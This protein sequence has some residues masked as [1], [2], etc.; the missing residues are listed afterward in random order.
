[1]K[2]ELTAQ[3]YQNF[4]ERFGVLHDAVIHGVSFEMFSN[5]TMEEFVIISVGTRDYS[6][7]PTDDLVNL[8]LEIHSVVKYS[9]IRDRHTMVSMLYRLNVGFFG[10]DIIFN[11]DPVYME[12]TTAEEFEKSV[13]S[14][15]SSF[16]IVGRKCFWY[17]GPYKGRLLRNI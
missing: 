16:V 1:M 13:S 14:G 2:L 9:L 15:D 5:K 10:D 8:Y 17:T 3:T 7:R 11:F 6:L 12:P 4:K